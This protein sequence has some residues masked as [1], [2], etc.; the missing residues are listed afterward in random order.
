M[1]E[2]DPVTR[3]NKTCRN[4]GAVSKNAI[5][6]KWIRDNCKINIRILDFGAG[7]EMAHVKNLR[8]HGF[9]VEG[10]EFGENITKDHIQLLFSGRFDVVYASN[11]FNTHSNALMTAESLHLIRKTLVNGG[12]FIFNLP[13]KP[14]YF[15]TNKSDFLNLVRQIFAVNPTKIDVRGIYSLKRNTQDEGYLI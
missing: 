14:N 7:K 10:Y 12:S 13:D 4:K 2:V 8:G 15:W 3:S 5:V 11:V 1:Q 6:P 9:Q